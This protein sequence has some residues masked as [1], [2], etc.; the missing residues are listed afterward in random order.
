MCD[1]GAPTGLSAA[2]T[3][4][5]RSCGSAAD[6]SGVG[7]EDLPFGRFSVRSA[8]NAVV[9]RGGLYAIVSPPPPGDDDAVV[10]GKNGRRC[11]HAIRDA[12]AAPAGNPAPFDTGVDRARTPGVTRASSRRGAK[13]ARGAR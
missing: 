6:A 3:A 7:Y 9:A 4:E 10:V 5:K 8:E 1:D 13:A 12:S 2:R 11:G